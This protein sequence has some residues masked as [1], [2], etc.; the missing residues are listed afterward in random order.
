[1]LWLK[2][3]QEGVNCQPGVQSHVRAYLLPS[4]LTWWLAGLIS[5]QVGGGRVSVLHEL[6]AR[7]PLRSLPHGP[8]HR[9]TRNMPTGFPQRVSRMGATVF[10]WPNFGNRI[11][12]PLPYSMHSKQITRSSPPLRGGDNIRAILEALCYTN[13]QLSITIIYKNKTI[14]KL[15]DLTILKGKLTGKL[16][17]VI[18]YVYVPL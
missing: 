8:L 16:I 11:P 2:F 7:G 6:S 15:W 9:A 4:S 1:M 13:L 5:S 14:P 17:I 18:K 3:S 12:S 10:L